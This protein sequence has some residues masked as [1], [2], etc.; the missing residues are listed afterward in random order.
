M[1]SGTLADPLYRELAEYIREVGRIREN[2]IDTVFLGDWFGDSGATVT[3]PADGAKTPPPLKFAVHKS[4][5]SGRR[6]LVVANDSSR[7]V[8]YRWQFAAPAVERAFLHVPFETP[9]EIAS[10][11]P[12][13]IKGAGLHIIIT[14]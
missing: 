11:E 14:S 9:R 8:P 7:P 13:E 12:L 10:G 3:G 6:A 5:Q 2:L 4:R 1:Y